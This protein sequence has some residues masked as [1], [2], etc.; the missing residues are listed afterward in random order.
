M[1]EVTLKILGGITIN[2]PA[3]VNTVQ[4]H[5][6]DEILLSKIIDGDAD[7]DED[8]SK[9]QRLDTKG[10]FQGKK[11]AEGKGIKDGKGKS[12]KGDK[13]KPGKGGKKG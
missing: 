2:V 12:A 6:G 11:G 4:I 8:L 13:V 3:L 9:R 10:N 5:E 7:A 1:K